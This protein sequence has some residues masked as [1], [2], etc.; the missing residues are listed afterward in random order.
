MKRPGVIRH[1]MD[2]SAILAMLLMEAGSDKVAELLSHAVLSSVNLAEVIAKLTQRGV[3][4]SEAN[5]MVRLLQLQIMPFD[6]P[7]ALASAAMFA[8]TRP[9]GLSLGDRACLALAQRMNLPVLTAD[10][11]WGKLDLGIEVKLIR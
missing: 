10:R 8:P 11:V 6:E 9:H 5:R 1:I 7:Q 2:S 3:P 4:F